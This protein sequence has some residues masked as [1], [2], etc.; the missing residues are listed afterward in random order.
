VAGGAARGAGKRGLSDVESQLCVGAIAARLI[1][2]ETY[3]VQQWI[4]TLAIVA[5]VALMGSHL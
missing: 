2:R 3:S 4:G 5:G 1:W